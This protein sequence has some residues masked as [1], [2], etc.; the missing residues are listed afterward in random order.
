MEIR[1]GNRSVYEN[2]TLYSYMKAS[3]NKNMGK[4]RKHFQPKCLLKKR[5]E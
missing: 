2:N 5:K 3:R 4:K 1:E